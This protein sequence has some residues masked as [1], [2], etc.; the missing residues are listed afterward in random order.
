ML[1]LLV[2]AS[3]V[4]SGRCSQAVPGAESFAGENDEGTGVAVTW[5]RRIVPA[6]G[7]LSCS[8]VLRVG[9]EIA[10]IPWRS[11]IPHVIRRR[12]DI[13]WAME[14]SS[15]SRSICPNPRFTA[16]SSPGVYLHSEIHW[17]E[18]RIEISIEKNASNEIQLV[19][20]QNHDM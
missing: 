5:K 14:S 6:G 17:F 9:Q 3:D 16:Q 19:I 10:S 7:S 1:A 4:E 8:L 15:A 2:C 11:S 12:C 13:C 20:C 18:H